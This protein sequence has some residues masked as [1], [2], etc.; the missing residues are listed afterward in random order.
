M[1]NSNLSLTK[2]KKLFYIIYIIIFIL[3]VINV[4]EFI[5]EPIGYVRPDYNKKEIYTILT[6]E[7]LSDEDY[8][9]L[10]YQTG[11][12]KVAIDELLKNKESG[13]SE[14]LQFQ[15]NFFK[16]SNVYCEKIGIITSQESFIDDKGEK[17]YNFNLAPYK[18]GYV[19]VT[20][21][22]HS[23]GWRHGHAAIITDS[24]KG[25]TLEAIILGSNSQFQNINKWRMYPS[26]I[27]LKLKDT[28]QDSLDKIAD[29]AVNN[30]NNI[31]YSLTIGL[32]SSKNPKPEIIKG[33]QCSHLVWYPFMQFGYDI[34]SDKNWLVT[35]KDIAN[36][37]LFEVVQIFGVNPDDIWP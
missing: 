12:G 28:H 19:L 25:K 17:T 7:E 14:I 20:K 37:D 16:E 30:L 13:I 31:P 15:D 27:M 35:P 26:F 3:L 24:E 21:A 6:K 23:L 18:N 10:F 33:T 36:S 22:T 11:L 2:K 8:K 5:I 1:T 4:M 32:T 9:I 34:D 29:F